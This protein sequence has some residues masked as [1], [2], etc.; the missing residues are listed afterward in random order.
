MKI[1]GKHL[2]L[3]FYKCDP[4]VLNNEEKLSSEMKKITKDAG[5]HVLKVSFHKFKPH[6]VSGVII[7]SESHLSIHTWPEYKFAAIDVF[8]C[9]GDMK[10]D[11]IVKKLKNL[12]KTDEVIAVQLDRGLISF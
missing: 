12:L 4:N 6:G 7:I 2:I 9:S 10:T 3:E 8:T 5:G 11:L 1:L